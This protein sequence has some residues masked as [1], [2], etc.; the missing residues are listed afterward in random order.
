MKMKMSWQIFSFSLK[1]EI[2]IIITLEFLKV[3]FDVDFEDASMFH[4]VNCFLIELHIFLHIEDQRKY[5]GNLKDKLN[6]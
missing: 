4:L 3:D 5:R 2:L 6:L 1:I